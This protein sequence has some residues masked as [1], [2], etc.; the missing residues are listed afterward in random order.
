MVHLFFIYFIDSNGEKSLNYH[1]IREKK[2]HAK[3]ES[4]WNKI[5]KCATWKS[6][7]IIKNIKYKIKEAVSI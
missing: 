7:D 2:L 6:I 1:F 5:L 4:K 3:Q